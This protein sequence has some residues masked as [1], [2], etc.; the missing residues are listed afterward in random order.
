MNARQVMSQRDFMKAL[1]YVEFI[2]FFLTE[3]QDSFEIGYKNVLKNPNNN[4][5]SHNP[6]S[7]TR[8]NTDLEKLCV[9]ALITFAPPLMYISSLLKGDRLKHLGP[10]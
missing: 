9:F 5:V 7:Q 3:L 1:N 6:N 8:R 4:L 10:Y 2:L